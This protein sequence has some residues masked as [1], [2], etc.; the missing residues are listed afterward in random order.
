MRWLAPFKA[1]EAK[2][3]YETDGSISSAQFG[4]D[5]KTL[6]VT[7]SKDGTTVTYAVSLED[8]SKKTQLW[9]ERTPTTPT[10]GAGAGTGRGPGGAAAQAP[11]NFYTNPGS[12]VTRTNAFGAS[13][14]RISSKSEAFLSGT[15]YSRNPEQEAPRPFIDAVS[16]ADGKK[17]RVW[18]SSADVYETVS[19]WLDDDANQLILNRQ[20]TTMVPNAFLVSTSGG[21]P[22]ALTNNVDY[23]PQVTMAQRN[24]VR[25]TRADGF[26]FWVEV[27]MPAGWTKGEKLPAFF[28][29]YPSEFNDQAGYDRGKRTFNKNTFP[30]VSASSKD[31]LVL[32]GYAVVEPDCP[33][34]GPAGRMNDSYVPDLRNNLSATI[35]E[36][37]RLGYID[38]TRL[39]IGGHSYGAFS[40]VNAMVHTPFFKAGIAGDGAYNR[41]LTPMAFQ[42][43]QRLLWE[44]RETY[45]T[46]SP[47]LYAEQLTGALLMYHGIADQ[48]VGT[49][50]INSERLFHALDGLG[51]TAALYMYPYE[52]HGQVA[53]ETILDQW[54]RFVA[55]LDK[56][57]K[58]AGK[59][60]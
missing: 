38:R 8:T 17:R 24:R 21:E 40:T 4:S 25:V 54:A 34:V 6:I 35:D 55:W 10:A 28:W 1:D 23:A 51:K 52:D 46:M 49:H 33:I 45:L 31:L 50:P 43:E 47:M 27:T 16:L 39:G 26:K 3:I 9:S 11:D 32:M 19:T 30:S 59:A 53:K 58:D 14:V 29:F 20:S 12:L 37:D 36:L 41:M 57:V 42:T 18:Q 7:E 13:V 22:K 60:P 44:A 56:Y 5:G 2:P 48:N 15:Q